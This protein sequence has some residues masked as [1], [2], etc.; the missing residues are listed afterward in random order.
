L[1]AFVCLGAGIAPLAARWISEAGARLAYG[2]LIAAAYLAVALIAKRRV[3]FGGQFCELAFAFCVLAV[4]QVLN[5]SI[6]G[7]VGTLILHDVPTAG[8]PLASTVS[9]TVVIQLLETL[10]AVVPVV[11]LTKL[12]GADLGSIYARR[13]V[14]GGWLVFAVVFF[15]L[16][17][18]FMVSVALRPESPAQQLLPTHGAVPLERLLALSPA[19]WLVSLSN[20]FEEEFL[21]RGLFLQKYNAFFGARVSNVLQATV[22]AVAH[23]GI[24][25]TPSALLFIALVVFPLGL[26]TGYL[27]RASRGVLVPGMLHGALDMAIYL[28]FLTAAS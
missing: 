18:A 10:L 20:G 11:V 9:G 17:Y 16:F 4:V 23:A 3:L 19:L 21:F 25:Y 6:P 15:V 8:N 28:G 22:F 27:M 26:A 1:L 2:V 13:G 24:S 14:I 7:F 12:S 5:N